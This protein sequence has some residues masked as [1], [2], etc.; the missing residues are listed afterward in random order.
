MSIPH[1]FDYTRPGSLSEALAVLGE[2]GADARPLAGGTDLLPR[3]RDGLEHPSVLVDLKAIRELAGIRAEEDAV[4]LG[5][6]ATFTDLVESQ[7]VADSLP[8]MVEMARLMGS[9]GIRNRATIVGNICSGVPSCDS[10]PVLL[11]C[12]ARV[13]VAGPEGAREIPLSEWFVAPRST[14]LGRSEIVTGVSLQRPGP[15]HGGCFVKLRRSSGEDLAQASVAALALPD[16][17]YRVAFGAVAPTPVRAGRIEEALRG[18]AIDGDALVEV[19][20]LVSEETSPICDIRAS[21]EYREHMLPVMLERALLAAA[22]RRDGE[23][24]PYGEALL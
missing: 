16:G 20:G 12:D 18:R 19:R 21:R 15:G 6:L 23:G 1:E 14:S 8:V 4:T 9:V 11:V 3:L 2:S 13:H 24:P 22:S 7:E 10:G 17:S 5:A